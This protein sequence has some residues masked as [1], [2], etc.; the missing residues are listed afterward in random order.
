MRLEAKI[1]SRLSREW[2]QF[3]VS[4]MHLTGLN[5]KFY[6]RVAG[7]RI[8]IY[9]GV[10][11]RNHTRF[12]PIFLKLATFE[13][14]LKFFKQYFNVVSLEDYYQEKFSNK[15][16]NVCLTFD[17]GFANNY[18]YV[19]PLLIK[20][21]MPGTFFLTAIRAAGYDILW[22]DFLGIV[23][24]YGPKV[25]DFENE[26]YYKGQ[27][28][29]YISKNDGVTLVEKMR[30]A[31]FAEK[32]GMMERLYP[33]YPFRTKAISEDY[34]LQMNSAQI[35]ELAVHPLVT[36]GA[37][38]CYHNDLSRIDLE[39]ADKELKLSKKYLEGIVQKAVTSFAFPYGT[40]TPAVV[41]TAKRT[42]YSQLLAMDFLYPDDHND[43]A[44][45]ERFT[46]NPFISTANQMVA[47][48]NRKY[49]Y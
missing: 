23:S 33:L 35:R 22:N 43:Q 30:S 31:G 8:L 2:Q 19:L 39:S 42:G 28:N 46:V 38:S 40:Y 15:K 21:Q 13:N 10:C 1:L 20:Y 3:F 27:Y 11:L 6:E 45:R 47:N 26:I 36:V 41:E 49:A 14:H 34:W 25:I 4:T 37:H 32:A 18:K 17:D 9:H 12:N 16:F 7:C 29:K 48:I 44:M 24:K 5:S